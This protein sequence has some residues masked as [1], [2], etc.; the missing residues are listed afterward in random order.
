MPYTQRQAKFFF[1]KWKE[2][3]ADLAKANDEKHQAVE[4]A[5]KV[6]DL[7]LPLKKAQKAKEETQKAVEE[8]EKANDEKEKALK[9][10]KAAKQAFK[11]A[12]KKGLGGLTATSSLKDLR[13]FIDENK[14]AVRRNVGGHEGR[15]KEDI[16]CDIA[17]ALA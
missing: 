12:P 17:N 5:K 6:R 15:T 13:A 1:A 3:E 2:M 7:L 16:F 14:L 10:S 4:E 11:K 8:A 9:D